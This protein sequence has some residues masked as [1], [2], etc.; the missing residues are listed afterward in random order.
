MIDIKELLLDVVYGFKKMFMAIGVFL[1]AMSVVWGIISA[2]LTIFGKI[3]FRW[4]N[5]PFWVLVVCAIAGCLGQNRNWRKVGEVEWQ[6]VNIWSRA[7]FAVKTVKKFKTSDITCR[8]TF[9]S[10]SSTAVIAVVRWLTQTNITAGMTGL[11]YGTIGPVLTEN[12]SKN[13]MSRSL[14]K[15]DSTHRFCS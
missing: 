3:E 12:V 10:E 13:S 6:T 8:I 15:D 7:R 9:T 5:I 1:L 14:T 2:L 4:L 11:N